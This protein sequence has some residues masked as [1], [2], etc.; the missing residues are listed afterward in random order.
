MLGN[1][2]QMGM[3]DFKDE[4]CNIGTSGLLSSAAVITR[5]EFLTLTQNLKILIFE[6][7]FDTAG[8]KN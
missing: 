7:I 1:R 6:T 4:T 2:A 3:L 5:L 8:E